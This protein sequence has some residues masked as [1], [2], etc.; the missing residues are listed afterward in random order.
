MRLAIDARMLD[1]SGIGMYLS[2]ILAPVVARCAAHQT[3]VLAAPQSVDRVRELVGAAAE[4]RPWAVPPLSAREL[5]PPPIA[6]PGVLWWAPHYNVPLLTRSPMVVTLHDVLPL[7]EL[8]RDWPAAKRLGVR[9]WMAAIR[10]RA[11][12]VMCS[13]AFTRDEVIRLASL[14]PRRLEVVHLGV[15]QDERAA[16]AP[17]RDAAATPY[18]LF[19]GL[20]K[21]HKN[22]LGLLRAFES[23]A[24]TVPHRLVAVARHSAL[25]GVDAEALALAQRL[26][27]R[28][29]ILDGVSRERLLGLMA[30]ADLL[31]QPSFY[32]GFGLPPL[33][34][35]ALGTPVLSSRAASL[36]ELC[37]DAAAYF[38][39]AAP[40]DLA[41]R[42]REVLA[43]DALRARMRVR[44]RERVKQF[45]WEA[46]AERTA[47]ILLAA[48]RGL[49]LPTTTG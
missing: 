18:L 29:E 48:L 45:T 25:R 7:S 27:P 39:A 4:C 10:T 28:V 23:I 35:M 12:R 26:A 8:G 6:G 22:L 16:G 46:C 19:V 49:P 34:A 9:A 38:D 43:D 5:Q 20:L 13:S 36:P 21:P 40:G 33:E 2:R 31:V 44:G 1:H 24:A 14:D 42:L 15:D 32:E 41:Q 11:V 17:P 30:G 37:G 47:A 3:V